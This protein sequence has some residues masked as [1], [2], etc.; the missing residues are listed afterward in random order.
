[1]YTVWNR[2]DLT[3]D[4]HETMLARSG[5]GGRTW[6]PARGV[7]TSAT[8]H[9]GTVGNQ[10]VVTRTGALVNV[11]YEGDHA[12]GGVPS[13]A[14]PKSIRAIR[15]AD[16]GTT[17]AA[18]VTI[19]PI[20]LNTPLLPDTGVAVAAPGIVPDVAADPRTGVI[21][22]TWADAALAASGSG[23]GLAASY[24]EGR[25]WSRPLRVDRAPESAPGGVGQAFLPQVDVGADGSVAV[26][27]YDFRND[28]AAPGD[29]TDVWLVRCRGALCPYDRG[30]W[31][32]RHV[33][34]P[35]DLGTALTWFGAPFVGT[36]T[37]LAHDPCDFV[38]AVVMTTGDPA[39]VQDIYVGRS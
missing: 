14:L 27:S 22:A 26:T 4:S 1:V 25:H 13:P 20:T 37:G 17:W 9:A 19:S 39:N 33:A 18:P 6:E 12:I 30:A 28:S 38:T 29:A 23:V 36:Y 7:Y 15:S 10:V 3:A 16:H 32:E 2:R 35:F 11:F 34:G 8:P 21:Y 5:D 24:D 31:R